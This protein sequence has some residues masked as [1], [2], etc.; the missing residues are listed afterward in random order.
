MLE[1]NL[2]CDCQQLKQKGGK[3]LRARKICIET[4]R[5]TKQCVYIGWR[6][7]RHFITSKI[8]TQTEYQT[9][10]KRMLIAENNHEVLEKWPEQQKKLCVACVAT[11]PASTANRLRINKSTVNCGLALSVPSGSTKLGWSRT[12]GSAAFDGTHA[13]GAWIPL[14]Q[15]SQVQTASKHQSVPV[16]AGMQHISGLS[17]P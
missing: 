2:S 6:K 1:S 12:S 17:P 7:F 5:I 14:Q 15:R 9:K 13:A 16:P 4:W 3:A 8:L 11:N 10:I